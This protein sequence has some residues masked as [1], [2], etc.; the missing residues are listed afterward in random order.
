MSLFQIYFLHHWLQES[1]AQIQFCHR[2]TLCIFRNW[3]AVVGGKSRHSFKQSTALVYSSCLGMKDVFYVG[4]VHSVD[5]FITVNSECR[6]ILLQVYC[7]P[8]RTKGYISVCVCLCICKINWDLLKP[9]ESL[10]HYTS[11]DRLLQIDA[12]DQ[13]AILQLGFSF[14]KR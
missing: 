3:K 14:P 1:V 4:N 2:L 5:I 10:W 9:V 8:M 13:R 12:C 6:R 7:F 11:V